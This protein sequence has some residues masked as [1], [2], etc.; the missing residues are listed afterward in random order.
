MVSFSQILLKIL[1]FK[2]TVK[3]FILEMSKITIKKNGNVH[4][5]HCDMNFG[6]EKGL[7]AHI[8]WK[9]SPDHYT[10]FKN[11][12]GSAASKSIDLDGL[13]KY[14]TECGLDASNPTLSNL[15]SSKPAA[16]NPTASNLSISALKTDF[17]VN[18]DFGYFILNN[19]LKLTF[20]Y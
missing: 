14:S 12:F 1:N 8:R 13:E 20:L 16:S 10:K 5:T 11:K 4:C 9:H 7:N 6:N 2:F 17:S 18:F 15:T 3:Y 19:Y